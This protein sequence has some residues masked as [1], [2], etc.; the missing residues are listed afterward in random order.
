MC[1]LPNSYGLESNEGKQG[2]RASRM[3]PA[4]DLGHS[5]LEIDVDQSEDQDA[6]S[7]ARGLNVLDSD[8]V[9][10]DTHLTYRNPSSSLCSS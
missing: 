10:T 6:K 1:S 8:L 5:S 4:P 2:S 9:K 7:R 3:S